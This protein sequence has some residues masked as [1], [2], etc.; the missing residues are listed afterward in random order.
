MRPDLYTEKMAGAEHTRVCVRMLLEGHEPIIAD[1]AEVV[2]KLSETAHL[3]R[4]VARTD[5]RPSMCCN[6]KGASEQ[7]TVRWVLHKH[8]RITAQYA[9]PPVWVGTCDNI[10]FFENVEIA[11]TFSG[12]Y[13]QSFVFK[14]CGY[15]ELPSENGTRVSAGGPWLK[16]LLSSYGKERVLLLDFIAEYDDEQSP[17]AAALNAMI[18]AWNR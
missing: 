18:E 7:F 1:G 3:R 6:Y 9:P 2:I 15:I 16:S 10:D 14:D 13:L 17:H 8:R 5:T 12:P 11:N 4:S